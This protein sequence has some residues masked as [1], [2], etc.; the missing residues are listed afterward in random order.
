[1]LTFVP[2]SSPANEAGL[3]LAPFTLIVKLAAVLPKVRMFEKTF[4]LP[5]GTV[6]GSL[7]TS[8][9][10][11]RSGPVV[12]KL[13][14][15]GSLGDVLLMIVIEAGKMAASDESER[16]WLPPAPSRLT[17][18]VWYGEP[19]MLI[20]EAPGQ[21]SL[22]AMCPPQVSTGF[23]TLAVKLIAMLVGWSESEDLTK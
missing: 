16:S 7:S 9:K 3:G 10:P 5:G 13:K 23:V 18:R 8:W 14:T 15:V 21:S 20:A 17:R 11:E 6:A 1:M 19:E 4:V 12:V 22:V 2:F